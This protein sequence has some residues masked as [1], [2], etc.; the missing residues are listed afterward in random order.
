MH[1]GGRRTPTPPSCLEATPHAR[2]MHNA[3]TPCCLWPCRCRPTSRVACCCLSACRH[4]GS[5]WPSSILDSDQARRPATGCTVRS[6]QSESGS[7]SLPY[8]GS[9]VWSCGLC[10]ASQSLAHTQAAGAAAVCTTQPGLLVCQLL[11]HAVCS[12]R[13]CWMCMCEWRAWL[14]SQGHPCP[15]RGCWRTRVTH[16]LLAVVG[17]VGVGVAVAVGGVQVQQ[18]GA[19]QCRRS[20]PALCL[21]GEALDSS[22]LNTPQ[23]ATAHHSTLLLCVL[24]RKGVWMHR[25]T[26]PLTKLHSTTCLPPGHST[27]SVCCVH[28]HVV[29]CCNHRAHTCV[30]A[31]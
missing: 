12:Q 19:D 7:Q 1:R 10:C 3:C 20:H 5:V 13:E 8:T 31:C 2:H 16:S 14:D 9:K 11:H 29:I 30:C 27:L 18:C 4:L 17:A 25:Q 26:R 28:A 6:W 23:H 22:R 24:T 21:P 15:V